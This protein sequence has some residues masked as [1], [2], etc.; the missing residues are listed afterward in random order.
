MICHGYTV[1][2]LLAFQTVTKSGYLQVAKSRSR[3]GQHTSGVT[4]WCTQSRLAR[5]YARSL[6]S[7]PVTT[8][9][10][11]RHLTLR[12]SLHHVCAGAIFRLSPVKHV[13]GFASGL[14][15]GSDV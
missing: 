15:G 1:D 4:E 11:C 9:A 8:T 2:Y 7:P 6:S 3:G 12:L 13:E 14:I 10:T 5:T